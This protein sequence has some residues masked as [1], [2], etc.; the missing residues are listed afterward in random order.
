MK[1]VAQFQFY[2]T[3]IIPRG[4][5]WPSTFIRMD[6]PD[7]GKAVMLRPRPVDEDLFPNDIDQTLA[8]MTLSLSRLSQPAGSLTLVVRDRCLDRVEARV[9]S[10]VASLEDVLSSPVQE[11]FESVA[12]RATNSFLEH[13]RVLAEAPFVSGVERH[14]RL[15]D[16]R[17]YMVNPHTIAWFR[18][19]TGACIPAYEGGVNATAG[20]GAVRSPER[21][22]IPVRALTD[23]LSQDELPALALSLLMDAE[24]QLVLLR[25]RESI[26]SLASACEVASNVYIEQ[27]NAATDPTVRAILASRAS[28]AEKRFDQIPKHLSGC[29]LKAEDLASFELLEKLYRERNNIIHGKADPRRGSRLGLEPIELRKRLEASRAAVEWLATLSLSHGTGRI[30]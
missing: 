2:F 17:Y 30:P 8:G 29:T 10:D 1:V 22:Q 15:Q 9:E 5:D 11:G 14:Y 26:L 7:P 3:F 12:I 18:G 24:E 28:F 27:L 21:G 25:L 4:N 23:S 6:F 16:G 19:D 20:S 13:C